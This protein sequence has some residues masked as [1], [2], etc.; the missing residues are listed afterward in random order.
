MAVKV[1]GKGIAQVHHTFLTFI[2]F[3]SPSTGSSYGGGDGIVKGKSGKGKSS[4]SKRNNFIHL[5]QLYF[6]IV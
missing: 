3:K 6:K 5:K 1:K 2:Y 4:G